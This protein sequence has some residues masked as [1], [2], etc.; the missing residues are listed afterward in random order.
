METIQNVILGV[1]GALLFFVGLSRLSNPQK[2]FL[3]NSGINLPQD[4]SLRNELRGLS[5]VMLSAG[6]I[7]L[8]GTIVDN[9]SY[10]SHM[11][12][13]IL[14]LGFALGRLISFYTDGKPSK[15]ISQGIAFD[16]VLGAA[17]LFCLL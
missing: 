7:V 17:N 4:T 8:L 13:V 9:H 5:A 16:L 15:Q 2:M 6:L 3:K 11:V 10:T 1:S 12:A 14:L